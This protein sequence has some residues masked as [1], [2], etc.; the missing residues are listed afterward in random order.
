MG[1]HHLAVRRMVLVIAGRKECL[2]FLN[3]SFLHTGKL[4]DLHR[5]K[6]LQLF[7]T[8]LVIHIGKG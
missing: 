5:P 2:D 4:S 1:L 8:G 3:V 7:C 6:A